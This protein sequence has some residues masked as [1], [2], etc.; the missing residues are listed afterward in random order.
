[1]VDRV[2]GYTGRWSWRILVDRVGG[3]W[4]IELEDTVRKSWRILLDRVGG[5][6]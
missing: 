5:Y 4:Y 2:G 6:W 3:Y 1:M